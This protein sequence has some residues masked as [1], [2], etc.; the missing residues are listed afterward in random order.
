MVLVVHRS[1]GFSLLSLAWGIGAI[2]APMLGG[3]LCKPVDKYPALVAKG[4]TFDEFPYLLPCL[5]VM[6]A[7]I[8]TA[9][10][11]VF[12]MRE[13]RPTG[14]LIRSARA[15]L[16]SF[17]F[18]QKP[19]SKSTYQTVATDEEDKVAV[20]MHELEMVTSESPRTVDCG[21]SSIQSPDTAETMSLSSPKD[22]TEDTQ[23]LI[24]V[25]KQSGESS[26]DHE[27]GSLNEKKTESFLTSIVWLTTVNYGVLSMGYIIW[28][29]T[30]PMYFKMDVEHVSKRA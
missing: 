20:Q 27:N 15:V 28:E 30:M 16:L 26:T 24:Q 9:L 18:A 22:Y 8:I 19:V 6:V 11:I 10:C 1:Y 25:T 3:T 13:T 4:S 21:P 23:N 17:S 5:F 2:I 7:Q 12:F 29:E 14:G